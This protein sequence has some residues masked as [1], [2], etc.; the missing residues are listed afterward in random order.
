MMILVTGGAG[1]IGSHTCL[2]L[3]AK[4]HDIIVIDNLSNSSYE[5]IR[6]VE[7]LTNKKI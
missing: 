2:A 6:R 7:N 3:I 4:G 5:S 1:Y